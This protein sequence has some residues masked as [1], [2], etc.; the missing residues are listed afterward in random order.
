MWT[1]L[2]EELQHVLLHTIKSTCLCQW[3]VLDALCY[4]GQAKQNQLTWHASFK[5]RKNGGIDV[6]NIHW[7]FRVCSQHPVNDTDKEIPILPT[8]P[9]H[10]HTHMNF[11]TGDRYK[12]CCYTGKR[13][14]VHRKLQ[15]DT[16]SP[17]TA[18]VTNYH[19]YTLEHHHAH[20]IYV[21]H[22]PC[23]NLLT[24]NTVSHS[25]SFCTTYY[26]TQHLHNTK[27]F[28]CLQRSRRYGT[29]IHVHKSEPGKQNISKPLTSTGYTLKSKKPT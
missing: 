28:S 5:G 26:F 9:T 21:Y 22:I 12:I 16:L 3:R 27:A 25:Q 18:Q 6:W 23:I 11:I 14:T 17:S 19:R 20:H 8:P 13:I 10:T 7:I 2:A 29:Y 15:C 24:S 1:G 4:C